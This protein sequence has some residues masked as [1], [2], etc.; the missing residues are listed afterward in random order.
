MVVNDVIRITDELRSQLSNVF[1]SQ[2]NQIE[3][4]ISEYFIY[5][6]KTTPGNFEY[7]NYYNQGHLNMVRTAEGVPMMSVFNF[8]SKHTVKLFRLLKLEKFK[9]QL[10]GIR[11][12]ANTDL[13]MHMDLNRGDV[14]RDCPIYSIMLTGKGAMV[15]F[16]NKN[17]GSRLAAVPPFSEFIMYPTQMQH[18]AL[19]Y[20]ED[21]DVLQ[22]RLGD[23]Y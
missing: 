5:K 10:N 18:G 19:T 9:P 1:T 17:D 14:G 13:P 6:D 15:F 23:M 2:Y 12:F 16:S 20:E 11:V 22:I 3:K 8:D 4:E 7:S 21:M